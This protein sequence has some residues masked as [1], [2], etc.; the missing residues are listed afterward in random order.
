MS[1]KQKTIKV[2]INE[3]L[4]ASIEGKNVKQWR[5]TRYSN[6]KR[7]VFVTFEEVVTL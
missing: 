1:E 5:E 7:Y 3:E 6:G 2:R 4:A